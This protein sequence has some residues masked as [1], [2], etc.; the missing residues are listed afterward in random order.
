MPR[1]ATALGQCASLPSSTAAA[2]LLH[3]NPGGLAGVVLSTAGRAALIGAGLYV[4]GEREHLVRNA[5]AGALAIEV[6]VL[7]WIATHDGD[8]P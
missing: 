5:V 8:E 7:T 4:A 2:D 6:F 3:G 1:Q